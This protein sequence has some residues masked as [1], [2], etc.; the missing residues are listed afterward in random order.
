VVLSNRGGFNSTGFV[1][2][3]LSIVLGS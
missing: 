1:N 2:H 3:I